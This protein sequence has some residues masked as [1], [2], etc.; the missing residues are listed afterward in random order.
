MTDRLRPALRRTTVVVDGCALATWSSEGSGAPILLVHG[1]PDTHNVWDPIV[2][3][4][5][6]EFRCLTYDVRGAGAS[7][8]PSSQDGY[9]LGVLRHDLTSVIDQ[10]SPH[11]PVHLVGHDWGSVQSWDA[12]IREQA[13]RIASFT[14]I[15]GPCLQHAS[16]FVQSARQAGWGLHSGGLAKKRAAALQAARLWY[17][18]AFQV[19]K[20]P[21]LAL[22]RLSVRL[23]RSQGH[24]STHF[25]PTLPC[26][27][28]NG[29]N[30]YRANF[31]HRDPMPG[32]PYTDLPVQLIVP[33]RDR[34]VAP[35]MTRNVAR[36]ASDL[37][38]VE[39]DAGHWA[40]RTRPDEISALLADFVR[41][42]RTRPG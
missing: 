3:R 38:R 42:H 10:L 12:V 18:Y 39:I 30:L 35:A 9:R 26:D 33:L 23:I 11:E 19:P 2:D 14:T 40:M 28:V 41:A 31:T 32:G 15:S 1:Y 22:R 25:G 16:A 17:V 4:L 21:E 8:A 27:S 5:G 36:F 29:L 7:D 37:T 6:A 13:G 24:A 20:V 34:Y